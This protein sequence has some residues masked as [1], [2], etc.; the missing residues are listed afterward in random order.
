MLFHKT[1]NLISLTRP[2]NALLSIVGVILG[3]WFSGNTLPLSDLILL[4]LGTLFTLSFG[5]VINDIKDIDGDKVNHPK[6]ALPSNSVSIKEAS[7]F[8]ITLAT[9]AILFGF[10]ISPLHLY[11]ILAPLLLLTLYTLYLKAVPLV[12]NF[13]IS[14]LVSYTLFFGAIGGGEIKI[15]IIPALLAFFL[16]FEREIIKDIE[17]IN[18]DIK[19]GVKT[20]A[21][22]PKIVIHLIFIFLSF[23]YLALLVSPYLFG[24]FGK[25]YLYSSLILILPLH[26]LI[27]ATLLGRIKK[28]EPSQISTLIKIEMLLGLSTLAIDK[29]I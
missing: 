13:L 3:F 17:D 15:I 11:A 19:T 18:G 16:N 22:L 25:F 6:R 9:F 2:T 27:S 28:I 8:A 20:T 14:T 26:I 23:S 7:L 5:N 4:T 1:V 24:Y 29:L 12:G 10:L 21:T